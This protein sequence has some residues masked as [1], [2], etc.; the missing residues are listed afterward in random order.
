MAVKYDP[1]LILVL[2]L[3]VLGAA[4]AATP[5][6]LPDIPALLAQVRDHQ[7]ALDKIK[8]KY[9]YTETVTNVELDKHGKENK[10][11]TTTSE[12]S[13]YRHREIDR[14]VEKNGKPISS[15]DQAKQQRRIEKLI[16]QLEAGKNPP[17]P[18]ANRRMSIAT[19]LRAERFENP[20]R[21]VFRERNVI[22]FD[23]EPDPAFKP[24]NSYESFYR[25][26]KGT[27]WVDEADLQV[28]RV[29]FKLLGA[30]KIGGGVFF[31]MRP[32]AH[33]VSEQSRFF[34]EVWLPTSAEVRFD[35]RALLFYGF[36]IE[37]TTTFGNYR[38]FDVSTEEKVKMPASPSKPENP[39]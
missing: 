32:G 5:D 9:T 33:F 1:A 18:D 37:E 27:M 26:M 35:G 3:T 14:L 8:E 7:D 2:V 25:L 38:R 16:A 30:F 29:D 17:D 6:Q 24:A 31:E 19:L 13:F 23:F 28:A 34:G 15:E 20:R 11:E 36:G 22:V 21:E 10:R 12:V 39:H 4:A